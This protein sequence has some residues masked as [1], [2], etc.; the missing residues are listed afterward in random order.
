MVRDNRE[1]RAKRSGF[2][3]EKKILLWY[4]RI[5]VEQESIDF[6]SKISALYMRRKGDN[7]EKNKDTYNEKFKGYGKKG[8][9]W[10]VPDL[11]PVCLQDI[12]H[13]GKPEL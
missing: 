7:H 6:C 5:I 13:R 1:N 10:R 12:L 3:V 4:T 2:E 11:L 8:W 9:V